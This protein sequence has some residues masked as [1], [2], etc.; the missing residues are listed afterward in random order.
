MHG[1]FAGV[2]VSPDF[3]RQFPATLDADV[4]GITSSCFFLGAFF[5]AIAAFVLGDKLGRR[6]TI[7][8]GVLCNVV[9]SVL[10]A[11]SWHL[12]QMIVGRLV[13]GFGI[14]LVSSMS[15]VYL[16]ECAPSH[17]R[18]ML[19][20]VGA[21]CNVAC[22]C[23]ANWIA[24]G[25]YHD[26]SAFQ[27]RFPLAFQLIFLFIVAPI[28]FFV[29]E[30]PRW[31]LL[32]DRDE[33]ALHVLSRLAGHS[34]NIGESSVTAEYQ[35]IKAAIQMERDDR[36]PLIDVLCHRDKSQNFRRLILGCGTQFM[37]QFRQV[38]IALKAKLE[39]FGINAL[40]FYLPTLLQ[41]DVGY[42]QQMSRLITAIS[43]TV[44]VFCSFVCL[45]MIDRF[46]RRNTQMGKVATAMFILYH[47]FF[48]LGYS[49]VPWVYSAEVSSLGWRTRG[50]AAATSVNWLGGFVVVQFTKV[51]LDNLQWRFFLM[52]GIFCFAFGPVVYFFYP[53]T[54]NRTL[55]D[56]DQIF[57]Q[58]PSPFVFTSRAA[59]QSQRP[60][61][62]IE[63]ETA[64]IA[65]IANKSQEATL[66]GKEKTPSV[67]IV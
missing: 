33:E 46:G 61:G 20:A 11:F 38:H 60:L 1:V 50:A 17:V 62:L 28:L 31:L 29:P 37:Q 6:R 23:V 32:V 9:G 52:F 54:A 27:W 8:L 22:F 19:L 34:K 43:S 2:L 48:G 47:V 30:S 45:L 12:P 57:I 65:Q 5:G 64:R 59:T 67:S 66:A 42:N 41:G 63:A 3:L 58:N 44:Y 13:N 39:H 15:P 53:E 14:G 4:S 25:L 36:V 18:G 49:S 10:Q 40:G 7:A 35:S 16:S 26:D 51:G 24:F 55:E 21:C 56:M